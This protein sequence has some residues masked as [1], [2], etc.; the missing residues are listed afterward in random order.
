MMALSFVDR[1]ARRYAHRLG[2]EQ[3][4]YDAWLAEQCGPDTPRL[5][6][7]RERWMQI[8]RVLCPRLP[9]ALS[10]FAWQG[11]ARASLICPGF[12]WSWACCNLG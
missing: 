4:A 7:W 2:Q 3:W 11:F 9:A 12:L 10:T 6:K 1:G 5:P 8:V